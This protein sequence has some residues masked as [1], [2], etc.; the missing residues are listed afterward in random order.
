ME[1]QYIPEKITQFENQLHSVIDE[2]MQDVYGAA[3]EAHESLKQ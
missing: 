1:N 3:D 2:L